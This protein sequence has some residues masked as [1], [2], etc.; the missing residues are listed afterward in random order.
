MYIVIEGID[1]CGSTAVTNR[2]VR[3]DSRLVRMAPLIRHWE[4]RVPEPTA[5]LIR[6]FL[7]LGQP[8]PETERGQQVLGLLFTADR[9]AFRW[10]LEQWLKDGMTVVADRSALSTLV[11]QGEGLGRFLM[12]DLMKLVLRPHH[13]IVLNVDVDTA[14]NRIAKRPG[15]KDSTER[16]TV[17]EKAARVYEGLPTG[18]PERSSLPSSWKLDTAWT[19][20]DANRPLD[21][22]V[23]TCEEAI[24]K[25]AEF[26]RW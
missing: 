25:V 19:H 10:Q 23:S 17:L 20:V 15:A 5:E 16:R 12:H 18:E 24:L 3:E 8:D 2:L 21:E 4:P 13:V 9:V 11:Y 14:L 22:V 6:A 26:Q 1:G 7:R